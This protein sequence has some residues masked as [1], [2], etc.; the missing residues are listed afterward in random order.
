[1]NYY[2]NTFRIKFWILLSL[3]LVDL[4]SWVS[5]LLTT[6]NKYYSNVMSDP[7]FP[8]NS[9]NSLQTDSSLKTFK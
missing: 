7:N 4:P 1:M 2:F 3:I 5:F 8:K 9:S 6:L